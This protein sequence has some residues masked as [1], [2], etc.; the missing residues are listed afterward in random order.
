MTVKESTQIAFDFFEGV[1]KTREILNEFLSNYNLNLYDI[2]L[3]LIVYKHRKI[4]LRTIVNDEL[5]K[6]NQINK[7][8][9]NL[10]NLKLIDKKRL[11]K[12]ERTV[13]LLIRES[14]REQ[15][16]RVIEQFSD[17][18]KKINLGYNL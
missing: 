1:N 3:L 17:K 9:R 2:E 15:V 11:P 4:Q 7:S 8:V 14:S 13:Q 6:A 12:D 16:E 10:Y 18:V 5:I